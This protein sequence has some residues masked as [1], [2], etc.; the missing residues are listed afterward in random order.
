MSSRRHIKVQ[1]GTTVEE[2]FFTASSHVNIEKRYFAHLDKM[3]AK[4]PDYKPLIDAFRAAKLD[5]VFSRSLLIESI[6]AVRKMT[7]MMISGV[8]FWETA[9]TKYSALWTLRRICT[10]RW[11][12]VMTI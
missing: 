12:S 7:L 10:P 11:S 5:D 6:P 8:R 4:Y 9:G 1:N 2:G 3:A